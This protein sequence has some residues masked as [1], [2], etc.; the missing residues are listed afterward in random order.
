MPSL[1]DKAFP[2]VQAWFKHHGDQRLIPAILPA[3]AR[4]VAVPHQPAVAL[5]LLTLQALARVV[6]QQ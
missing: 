3:V 6:L 2:W 1:E 4:C 5:N